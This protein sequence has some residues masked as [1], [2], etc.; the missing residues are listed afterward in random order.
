MFNV[1]YWQGQETRNFDEDLYNR[2]LDGYSGAYTIN[3]FFN[4]EVMLKA[5]AELYTQ[6]QERLEG[7]PSI[8]PDG[9]WHIE[10]FAEDETS[11][12]YSAY[13][14]AEV[15]PINPTWFEELD[16]KV[17]WR[18]TEVVED[19]N[20]LM[21]QVDHNGLITKRRE[22]EHKTFIDE[23]IA[24][25]VTSPIRFMQQMQ[26]TSWLTVSSF[27]LTIMNAQIAIPRLIGTG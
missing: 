5:K 22:L 1:S 14:G 17:Y 3:H 27:L 12:E 8:Q 6:N 26:S 11:E 20:R 19:T 10:D 18:H 9:I 2:D 13:I 23:T 15:T 24:F 7:S 16:T 21:R 4:E 25:V